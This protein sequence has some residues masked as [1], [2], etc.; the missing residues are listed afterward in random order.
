M[1][2]QLDQWRHQTLEVL[3]AA[4]HYAFQCDVE[5]DVAEFGTMSGV[6]SQALAAA[7]AYG[8]QAYRSNLLQNR[9]AEKH[10]LLFDSFEGLPEPENAIDIDSPHCRN[11]GWAKGICKGLSAAELGGRVARILPEDRF[12][13]HPGWFVD[14][15]PGLSANQR[16]AVLHV[17][18]DLYASARDVLNGVFGR[19]LAAEGCLVLFDDWNANRARRDLGERR[20]WAEAVDE[21][22]IEFSDEGPYGFACRKFVVHDYAGMPARP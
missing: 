1:E 18:S 13:I 22:G 15:L 5:G 8:N 17:D 20:A 3:I 21:F 6:T 9:L 4:V 11:G 16:F 10:L 14:T 12:S 7:T 19:G 2:V